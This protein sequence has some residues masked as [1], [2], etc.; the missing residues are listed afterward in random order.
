MDYRHLAATTLL[1][2]ALLCGSAA[3]QTLRI[4]LAEDPDG[5]DPDQARTFVGRI[6]FAGLCDKLIDY[7][8]KLAYQPQLATAWK[9]ADDQ[10]SITFTLRQGVTFH[11]GEP[12]DAAAVKYNM[13]RKLT[14]PESRRKS[15]INEI[16]GVDVIDAH[17]VRFNLS[18]P[19]APLLAQLADRAGMMVAP[20]AAKAAGA[21]FA[22]HPVCAGPYKFVERVAQDRIVLERFA[23]YWNK[24]AFHFDRVIYQPIPDSTVRLANLQ[25]GNLDMIERLAPT[26]VEQV[27]QDRRLSVS[28]ITGLAYQGITINMANGPRSKGP[29]ADPRV[30][31]AL[32]LSIDRDAINQ[33]VF[34]GAFLSG[35]QPVPPESPY[36][37]GAVPIPKRDVAKAKALLA[38]AGQPAPTID[39]MV[40]STSEDQAVAQV[41]QSMA[42]ETGIALKLSV[43]EFATA[44]QEETKGNFEAFLIGWSGRIDP[45]GNIYNFQHSTGSLNFSKYH[46]PEVDRLLDAARETL[47]EAGR[48]KLYGQAAELYL[49][50]RHIIYLFHRKWLFAMSTKLKGFVANPDGLI[51]L[52][53]LTLQ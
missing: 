22:N 33:V 8:T 30:R 13:E 37:A 2:A 20:N 12:F 9:W 3:A 7:D 10:K 38:A 48:A 41:L 35:N 44:L 4:G 23:D 50:D 46:N 14:L 17:T 29:L 43:V 40:P 32:E 24:D 25:G 19:S 6:V 18:K 39:L 49:K 21:A 47:D 11:D 36:Y 16:V 31:E 53:G 26:D 45:D 1:S 51:R 42:Q 34:N 52:A 15:E 28:E 27:R 5:L